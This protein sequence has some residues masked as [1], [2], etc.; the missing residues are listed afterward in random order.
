MLEEMY[1]QAEDLCNLQALKV[2]RES[3]ESRISDLER[4]EERSKCRVEELEKNAAVEASRLEAEK[5]ELKKK[6][7]EAE[8]NVASFQE[9]I[10]KAEAEHVKALAQ[11]RADQAASVQECS[12]LRAHSAE[13][14]SSCR[15]LELE[16]AGLQQELKEQLHLVAEASKDVRDMSAQLEEGYLD[17]FC[18]CVKQIQFFNPGL[19]LNLRGVAPVFAFNEE[20]I[21]V[22][23]RNQHPV[24]LNDP[25][26]PVFDPDLPLSAEE[27]I[28]GEV[29]SAGV[30]QE[31]VQDPAAS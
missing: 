12:E 20:G 2:E 3:L 7:E 1:D 18:S 14:T 5:T 30:E 26:L 22:N 31:A 27:E 28:P 25:A 9:S 23:F 17:A 15:R 16:N 11:V 4:A 21:L 19:S 13:L 10:K 24:D 6:L 29:P 8:R